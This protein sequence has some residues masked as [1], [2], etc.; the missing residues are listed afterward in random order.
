MRTNDRT[1]ELHD[2][3]RGGFGFVGDGGGGGRVGQQDV[4]VNESSQ[5]KGSCT[6]ELCKHN[7][8]ISLT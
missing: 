6:V 3:L 5:G 8:F 1:K 2:S 4:N 7:S